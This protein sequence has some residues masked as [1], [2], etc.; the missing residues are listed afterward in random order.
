MEKIIDINGKKLK[1]VVNGSTPLVFNSITGKDYFA[2]LVKVEEGLLTDQKQA[3]T[4]SLYELIYV[5]SRT[6]DE[7]IGD[8]ME[9]YA[10]FEDGF[11]LFDVFQDVYDLLVE[12]MQTSQK[13]TKTTKTAKTTK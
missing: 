8:M 11:P 7:N 2:E 4:K 1:L 13:K 5:M 3:N 6:A 12:N 10:S 9:F